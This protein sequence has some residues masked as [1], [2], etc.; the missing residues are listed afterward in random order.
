M[1]TR[2]TAR[3]RSTTSL[4]PLDS[5]RYFE[6]AGRLDSF[7]KA[8]R[9]LD[10]TPAAV[11]HRIRMIEAYLDAELFE[12]RSRGV[13]LNRCGREFLASVQRILADLHAATARVRLPCNRHP[14]DLRQGVATTRDT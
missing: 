14:D 5:L 1:N 9:E 12:R 3:T 8:A 7:A 4:P 13:R 10:V 2:H 6:A 11:A